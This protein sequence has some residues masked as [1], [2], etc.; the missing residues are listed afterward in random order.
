[1]KTKKK[2]V[3]LAIVFMVLFGAGESVCFADVGNF[4]TYSYDTSRDDSYRDSRDYSH[5]DNDSWDNDRDYS[6]SRERDRDYTPS[7]GVKP[8]V[9]IISIIVVFTLVLIGIGISKIIIGNRVY[10]GRKP[11]K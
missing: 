11:K 10:S 5:N 6:E 9:L 8:E 1:M 4:E 7:N 2:F 3:I